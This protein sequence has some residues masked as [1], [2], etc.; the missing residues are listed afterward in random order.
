MKNGTFG[1]TAILLVFLVLLLNGCTNPT[2]DDSSDL[3]DQTNDD[4]AITVTVS[5]EATTPDAFEDGLEAGVITISRGD[6][7]DGAL[8]VSATVSGTASDSDYSETITS[9]ITIPNGEASVTV[10]ITPVDDS[11]READETVIIS[12]S[13][14]DSYQLSDQLEATITITSN[15]YLDSLTYIDDLTDTAETGFEESYSIIGLSVDGNVYAAVSGYADNGVT[16]LSVDADGSF[17]PVHTVF[18]D[19]TTAFSGPRYMDVATV[20]GNVFLVVPGSTDDG[21]AVFQVDTDGS[22]TITDNVT[23]DDDYKLNGVWAAKAIDVGTNTYIVL[24]GNEDGISVFELSSDGTVTSTDNVAHD[25]TTAMEFIWQI[26]TFA[27]AT[28]SYVVPVGLTSNGFTV[29]ELSSSG[30]L[31]LKDTVVDDETILLEQPYWVRHAEIDGAHYL[32]SG[33]ASEHGISSFVVESDGT[34]SHVANVADDGTMGIKEIVD[35]AVISDVSGTT[36][37]TA[38]WEEGITLFSIGDDGSLSVQDTIAE[39]ASTAFYYLY[40]IDNI[41]IGASVFALTAAYFGEGIASVQLK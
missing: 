29:F 10:T 21:F 17:S 24:G 19:G 20:G 4:T 23:D 41:K 34:V 13:E 5:I 1:A 14:S 2:G 36:L 26:E 6:S 15:D 7:T 39:S 18:D 16:I 27:T 8:E 11:I 25:G 31:T 38:S 37:V 33:G 12:V 3:D 35:G 32:Y 28:A 30:T 40:A 9:P 22:L